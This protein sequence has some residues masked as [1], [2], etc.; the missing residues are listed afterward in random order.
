MYGDSSYSMRK[1]LEIPFDGD[2]VEPLQTVHKTAMSKVRI[3]VEW[4]FKEVKLLWSLADCTQRLRLLR[5]QVGLIY[6]TAVLLTNV[7]NCLS[8][9]KLRS[10]SNV[11]LLPS[12]S[13]LKHGAAS[14]RIYGVFYPS[15]GV[16]WHLA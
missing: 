9:T 12:T 4:H 5:M 8:T 16:R 7:R 2:N 11:C 1:F 15:K 3:T 14:R 6:Q 10:I 13:I